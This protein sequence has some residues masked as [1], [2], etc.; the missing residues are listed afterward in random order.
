MKNKTIINLERL[1]IFLY[2]QA[3]LIICNIALKELTNRGISY[4]NKGSTEWGKA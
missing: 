3:D 2:Q 1:E 4:Q